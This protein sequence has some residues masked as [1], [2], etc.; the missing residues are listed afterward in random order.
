MAFKEQIL[1]VVKDEFP[2]LDKSY[3]Y[4]FGER[5]NYD[6]RDKLLPYLILK[7]T[8]DNNQ[9]A[10]LT[11]LD[12]KSDHYKLI[13]FFVS[14]GLA[15][16]A[17]TSNI[18]PN[19]TWKKEEFYYNGNFS[20]FLSY[21]VS[22]AKFC[23]KQGI[24]SIEVS[25][26]ELLYGARAYNQKSYERV[27]QLYEFI[28][29]QKLD[30]Q[31]TLSKHLIKLN[32]GENSPDGGLLLV[33]RK[34]KFKQI[35]GSLLIDDKKL[36]DLID[37]KETK[38]NKRISD[39]EYVD[40]SRIKNTKSKPLVLVADYNDFG[41]ISKYIEKYPH[42]TSVVF[43]DASDFVT[44]FKSSQFDRFKSQ[45][46]GL[47]QFR[48][49]YFV[50][51]E[52]DIENKNF[53]ESLVSDTIPVY[54][55]MTTV[56]DINDNFIP[57]KIEISLCEEINQ[58]PLSV[59]QMCFH[60]LFKHNYFELIFPIFNE[61]RTFVKRWNSFY[62]LD[63]IEENR[64]QLINE[65]EVLKRDNN[66]TLKFADDLIDRLQEQ[67]KK[68]KFENKKFE[69]FKQIVENYNSSK[70]SKIYLISENENQEDQKFI[71]E[72][73]DQLI[74]NKI[75]FIHVNQLKNFEN[76]SLVFSFG[77]NRR[78]TSMVFYKQVSGR[79]H[80][81]LDCTDL[82]YF[83]STYYKTSKILN[84]ILEIEKRSTLLNF[85][86][87]EYIQN[88]Q[89]PFD[90]LKNTL[91]GL[92]NSCKITNAEING[93]V[94]LTENPFLSGLNLFNFLEGEEREIA[95]MGNRGTFNRKEIGLK[96]IGFD[97]GSSKI[98]EKS[99]YLYSLDSFEEDDELIN[100]SDAV[101]KLRKKVDDLSE[102]DYILFFPTDKTTDLE[103]FVERQIKSNFVLNNL[104]SRAES[105]RNALKEVYQ[106][107]GKDMS[108]FTNLLSK[109]INRSEQTFKNW[110]SGYTLVPDTDYRDDQD[111]LKTIADLVKTDSRFQHI[112]FKFDENLRNQMRKMKSIKVNAPK[113]LL[114]SAVY[115]KIN[116]KVD[117][118]DN[119]QRD[120]IKSL[121]EKIEVKQIKTL[122]S[123]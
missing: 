76:D 60:D 19:E 104:N 70:L 83:K 50:L 48:D 58:N 30:N 89:L 59:S 113:M 55:W 2:G 85:S 103:E 108:R 123:I 82:I 98:Y 7:N 63:K 14:I 91:N 77:S 56:A 73:T 71:F 75:E 114:K 100:M 22:T 94:D 37:I 39:F 6:D 107:M 38:W 81:I 95:Q 21:D 54:N 116:L 117:I 62:N 47:P 11:Y 9:R 1:N 42:I 53:F 118:D 72:N 33:T 32:L 12:K 96:I 99:N 67:L 51:N 111:V 20:K 49:L 80:F 36:T 45:F 44:K 74:R 26:D 122:I 43:D 31:D 86:D 79:I 101:A 78:F 35:L 93:D 3:F 17:K 29:Q 13:P 40:L 8:L 84:D 112:N 57:N 23:L 46:L 28:N 41:S 52:S 10:I 66:E 64:E 16:R 115:D 106:V 92:K 121:S 110:L 109:Y 105:W 97:D 61:F 15:M 27:K 90:D 88:S 25:Y 87:S 5:V 120:L 24:K 69:Q 18:E 119:E 102:G 65:F 68:F 4:L 34:G